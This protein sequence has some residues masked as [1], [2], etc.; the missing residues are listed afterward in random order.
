MRLYQEILLIFAFVLMVLP[1]LAQE[2]NEYKNITIPKESFK[3]D[4]TF[5][6]DNN[7]I[8]FNKSISIIDNTR[9][10]IE[11]NSIKTF[12]LN[13]SQIPYTLSDY[14]RYN[15]S[16]YNR[17]NFSDYSI[18]GNLPISKSL[19]V[20]LERDKRTY[21][22]LSSYT[23]IHGAFGLR[24][25]DRISITGGL[26]VI[27]Q[28]SAMNSYTTDRF[29]VRFNLNYKMNDKINFNLWGQSLTKDNS[30]SSKQYDLMMPKT[31]TGVSAILKIGENSQIGVTTQ[32]QEVNPIVKGSYESK[33]KF[34]LK[35]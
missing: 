24:I 26:L 15:P 9:L 30:N 11:A 23:S 22:G 34:Q 28:S 3:S 14:N 2:Y 21:H 35:F 5:Q 19:F 4:Y 1:S 13:Q 31:S 27:K 8:E 16:N 17:S 7:I 25:N 6:R 32:Y 10:T 33:G 20:H 12:F 29:G 18:S